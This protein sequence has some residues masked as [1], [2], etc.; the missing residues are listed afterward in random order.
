ML[1]DYDPGE[2]RRTI[3]RESL[4][5]LAHGLLVPFGLS[6]DGHSPERK[7]D[8]RTLVFVHGLAA[9]RAGF[10]PLQAFLRSRGH[11]RQLALN[12]RSAGS[13]E[14][15]ALRLKRELDA[16]VRGGRIDMVAHSMGGLVARFY[17]QQLGGA[18]RVDRL[19]TL[20]T[21]HRG[22]HAANFVP[23]ALVRQLLPESPFIRHLNGLPAPQGLQVSSIVAG[24]DVLVQP[25]EAASCP[26]GETIR[27]DELGHV[28]LLFRPRVFAEIRAILRGPP[29]SNTSLG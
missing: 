24:R 22:T 27:F 11:Q 5:L 3:L 19:I 13:V 6:G 20:G 26:F 15:L 8:Q 16:K 21:P 14:A 23:S 4:S 2:V 9:N 29:R 1:S 28:E 7:R 12:Y 17:L 25:T 10:L 18:R